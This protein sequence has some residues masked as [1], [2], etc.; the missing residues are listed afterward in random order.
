MTTRRWPTRLPRWKPRDATASSKAGIGMPWSRDGC[1]Q[2]LSVCL[3]I[4][5]NH[6]AGRIPIA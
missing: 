5:L 4:T 1:C 2:N 6:R 3:E